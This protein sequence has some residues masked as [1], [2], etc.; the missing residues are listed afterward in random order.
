MARRIYQVSLDKVDSN[1]DLIKEEVVDL[2]NLRD[3]DGVGKAATIGG[4]YTHPME[5]MEVVCI[6]DASTLLVV[7]D[8]NY[9][10]GSPSRSKTKPDDNEFVLIRLPKALPV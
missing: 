4:I 3:P 9:P 6:V 1:G 5:S 2:M 8:N 7:N 10:G